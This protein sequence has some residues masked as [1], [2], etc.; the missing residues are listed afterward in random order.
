MLPVYLVALLRITFA[1]L[2]MGFV[3]SG[4]GLLIL[5]ALKHKTLSVDLL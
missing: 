1:W 2:V 5:V 3:F 4:N